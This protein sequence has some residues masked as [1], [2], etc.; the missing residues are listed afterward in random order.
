MSQNASNTRGD[1]REDALEKRSSVVR[2][3]LVILALGAGFIVVPRV[4]HGYV[5]RGPAEDAPDFTAVVVANAPDG[6]KSLNLAAL[7]G[8]PV[9]LDFWATWC[10]PCQAELPIM[11]GL[12]ARF[13]DKGLVVVGV[14]TS[15]EE[16][17]AAPLVARRNIGFPIVY[18]RGD[19]IASKYGVNN[20]PTLVLV[21]KE[22]KIV[23]VRRGV[24]SDSDLERLIRREL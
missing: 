5:N 11:N 15:D 14:N 4:M 2:S 7:R 21:S 12:A 13:K 8:H 3:V 9:L 1:V 19:A 22:G 18:D 6:Q 24:T 23:A 17:L 16:G 20:L 10:P